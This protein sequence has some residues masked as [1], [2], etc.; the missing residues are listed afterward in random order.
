MT[1]KEYV[2]QFPRSQRVAIRKWMAAEL[3]ISEIYV[4]SMCSGNKSIPAKYAIQIEK[5]TAGQVK[6]HIIAPHF[7]PIDNIDN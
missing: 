2:Q 7:Y 6:K 5:I 1:L 3:G 4:R